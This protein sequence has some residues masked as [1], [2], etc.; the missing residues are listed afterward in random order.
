VALAHVCTQDPC[1]PQDAIPVLSGG[2]S[3]SAPMVAAAAAVVIQAARLMN[4]SLTPT[5]VRDLLVRTGRP[6]SQAPQADRTLTMGTQLDVTA[7]V[8]SILGPDGDPAIARLSVA[9]RRELGDLGAAFREDA[10]PSAIDVAGPVDFSGNA[11]GQWLAGP[12]TIAADLVNATADLKFALIVGKTE[13]VQDGRAFR[14]LPA[15]LLAAAGLPVVS[16]TPRNV[17][18]RYEVRRSGK[19]IASTDSR[20]VFGPSDGLIT[21]PLAPVAPS[22]AVEGQDVLVHYDL[23]GLRYVDAPSIFVSGIGH[24]SPYAAP[25]FHLDTEIPLRRMSGDVR[26]PASAF[27]G[28]AGLYGIGIRPQTSYSDVGQIAVIRIAAA[29]AARPD[30]PLLADASGTFGHI[31]AVTRAAPRFSLRWDAS[32]FGDGAALEVSA[33]APS[34]RNAWNT[35]TNANGSRRDA[36][37]VDSTSMVFLPLPSASGEKTFDAVELGIAPGL[38]YN[39]RVFALRNGS[40]A[41][42]GSPSSALEVDDILFPAGVVT[43]FEL[44]GES[45]IASTATGDQSG[46]LASSALVRWSPQSLQLGSTVA[47]DS[48]GGTVYET[49]GRDPSLNTALAIRWPWNGSVQTLE[50][51]DT[52]DWRKLGSVDVDAWAQDWIITARVDP[53][54]HRAA[55][56]AYDPNFALQMLPFDLAGRTFGPTIAPAL[57]PDD[58]SF[59][60]TLT[61]DPN[62]GKAFITAAAVTDFC[63]FRSGPLTSVDLD[64]G[65]TASAPIDS[66]S[67][68]LVA[69]GK[70]VHVTHGPLFANGVLLPVARLQDVDERT[71]KAS[72]TAMLGARSP[73]FPAV[74]PEN[75]LLVIGFIAGDDYELNS[76]A[77]SALGVFDLRT[78][79]RT[80][81]SRAFNFAQV[82]LGGVLDPLTLR[83]IQLDPRTR[84]GWTIGAGSQQLQRFSY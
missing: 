19:V 14:L 35:F 84:T 47:I 53:V 65:A 45:S 40:L 60:N 38:F 1:T 22:V 30:A 48:K 27:R 42:E 63:I 74:D 3:A 18:F 21:E 77:T 59:Y 23:T 80:G 24:W 68:A 75:Q 33:P 52:R 13:L 29:S 67:T 49:I 57:G 70:K 73:I 28:G 12:I 11:T 61:L 5:Q 62:T 2:T 15:E 43:S 16:T 50:T 56:L 36:N 78:G 31:A 8:E 54:H 44:D 39:L 17:D 46:N 79:K 25:L 51:F 71:M 83:G 58:F 82:A 37:G 4:K 34:L 66:C 32:A 20:L 9:H 69:D 6:L 10:D 7:A 76:N 41:S 64:T 55:L 26:I 72:A 81:Y